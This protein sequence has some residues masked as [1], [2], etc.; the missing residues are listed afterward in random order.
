MIATSL[1]KFGDQFVLDVLRMFFACSLPPNSL[2]L[3]DNVF[4]NTSSYFCSSVDHKNHNISRMIS[5]FGYMGGIVL[6]LFRTSIIGIPFVSASIC[7]G[8]N[9]SP[10]WYGSVGYP[11]YFTRDVPE[12]CPQKYK[13]SRCEQ[14]AV[15]M[16]G[17]SNFATN[18]DG[19]EVCTPNK[20][21][22][23]TKQNCNDTLTCSD[24]VSLK[25]ELMNGGHNI[26]C[27]HEKTF[28]QQ[29]SGEVKNC[30]IDANCL[31]PNIKSTQRQL[32]PYGW[33]SATSV[34]KSFREMGIP[35]GKTYSSPFSRCAQHADLFSD[36]DNE[37]RLELLYMGGWR[38]VLAANNIT[39]MK[40]PNALKWQAYHL[41]NFAGKKPSPGTNNVM[42]T[43]GFNIK[44]GFGTPVDEGYCMV[45][46]PS[47]DLPSLAESIGS[48]AVANQVFNFGDDSFPVDAIARMSPESALHMQ[49]CD[50]VRSD[51]T[52]SQDDD[53]ILVSYDANHDMKIT[54]DEF[55][56]A[57]D[58]LAN[59]EDAF[60]FVQSVLIDPEIL[61]KTKGE[62][63]PYIQ[64]G[65]FF[66]INWGWREF[67]ASGGGIAYPWRTILE[68]TIGSGGKTPEDRVKAFKR[69]NAILSYLIIELKDETKFP[70]KT[71]MEEKLINCDSNKNTA[72]F[73]ADCGAQVFLRE[74]GGPSYYPMGPGDSGAASLSG[75]VLG[76][77]LAYPSEW[78]PSNNFHE[79]RA[80]KVA[81]C[82]VDHGSL[83]FVKL[84]NSLGC[85]A[86]SFELPLAAEEESSYAST[87]A[88]EEESFKNDESVVNSLAWT[89][90]T[91]LA[92][93]I[94][95]LAY[96]VVVFI[97]KK[98]KPNT[99][100]CSKDIESTQT[101]NKLDLTTNEI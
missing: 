84:S 21:C 39:E 46:K 58:F 44:L 29:Y 98:L 73:F 96:T 92:C 93:S 34:A 45:L 13:L 83:S 85:G 100:M 59:S 16:D 30:H 86:P 89:F 95:A 71:E 40:K 18:E 7:S 8:I 82:L 42:I 97:P 65:Q 4:N 35:I 22:F 66:H 64:L 47:D 50:E 87:L 55:T 57:H 9:A 36:D 101:T 79:S 12:K 53:D 99:D 63:S 90:G 70:S 49:T 80:L 3:W 5:D 27:R 25:D 94:F 61:G 1:L 10:N 75:S 23:P 69:A 17:T 56:S 15:M 60:D 68:N 81:S 11:P 51:L 32:Q 67:T 33:D 78:K 24:L 43:H 28:W 88:A 54:K 14:S 20:D 19:A 26:V 2:M 52:N 72:Q 37:E 62:S 6:A 41:R 76:N 74:S 48:L 38:E 77:K 91:L 31:D